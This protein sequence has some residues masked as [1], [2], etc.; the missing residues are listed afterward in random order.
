MSFRDAYRK[1]GT[2]LDQVSGRD[3]VESIRNRTAAGTA[4]NLRLDL[5]QE[6]ID[7]A[8]ERLASRRGRWA[9]A[10]KALLGIDFSVV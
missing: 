2:E 6:G 5:S 7:G 3:P 4:G 10:R 9:E 1:V 8:R